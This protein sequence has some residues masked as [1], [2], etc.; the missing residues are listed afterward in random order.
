MEEQIN[1][2]IDEDSKDYSLK[3][4]KE[5]L[6]PSSDVEQALRQQIVK[7]VNDTYLTELRNRQ[8]NTINVMISVVINHLFSNHSCVT[9]AMLQ[10]QEKLVIEMYCNPMHPVNV[11]F[12]KLEDLL[13]LSIAA[14]TD[15]SEQQ[16]I[17]LPM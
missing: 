11:I 8:T 7:A 12:N 14:S 2:K 6:L 10:H 1:K 3:N 17:I 15:F 9:P 16:L 5:I 13:D 4:N